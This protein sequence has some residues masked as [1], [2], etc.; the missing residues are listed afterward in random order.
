MP[1]NK[2]RTGVDDFRLSKPTWEKTKII[3]LI[4]KFSREI[5][6]RAFFRDR[7]PRIIWKTYVLFSLS[8]N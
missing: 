6:F 2:G 8:Y 1:M 7:M 3:S 4:T 5:I